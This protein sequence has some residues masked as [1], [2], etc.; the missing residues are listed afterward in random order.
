MPKT[1]IILRPALSASGPKGEQIRKSVVFSGPSQTVPP[2]QFVWIPL[3]TQL[4]RICVVFC[5]Q[6][7]HKAPGF[8]HSVHKKRTKWCALA[9]NPACWVFAESTI[10]CGLLHN[11]GRL[12]TKHGAQL[13]WAHAFCTIDRENSD[14]FDE[15]SEKE[16]IFCLRQKSAFFR[17]SEKIRCFRCRPLL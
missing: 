12:C 9:N 14:I 6:S 4:L 1:S 7:M 15:Q 17:C 5:A 8:V 3:K 11:R 2:A 13:R 16:P 10:L